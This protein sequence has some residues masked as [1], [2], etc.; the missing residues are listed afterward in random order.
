[1]AFHFRIIGATIGAG[2]VFTTKISG[3][4]NGMGCSTLKAAIRCFC[5]FL[6]A[7]L[8]AAAQANFTA[9]IQQAYHAA[10][11]EW[12]QNPSSVASAIAVA[13]AAC[14]LAEIVK[15]DSE[16]EEIAQL[17]IDAAREAVR[18][19]PNSAAAHYWLGMNF[20]ELARTKTL[21][22]LSLVKQMAEEFF[23]ARDLD[24]KVD[25]SGPNRSLGLLYRDAPGWPTSIGDKRKAR[26]Y[27]KRAVDVSPEFPENQLCLLETYEKWGERNNFL[28]QFKASEKVMSDARSKFSGTAWESNWADWESRFDK[29]KSAAGAVGRASAPKKGNRN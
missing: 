2:M 7:A 5:V 3:I 19:D 25:Y 10:R 1:M 28:S 11:E 24:E 21:G 29:M 6:P 14:D 9:R 13:H 4:R 17:G 20:G 15:S 23:K 26:D 12:R 8:L 22:A 27:L 16:R 18:S